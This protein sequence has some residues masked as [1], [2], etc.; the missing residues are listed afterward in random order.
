MAT[1]WIDGPKV[2]LIVRHSATTILKGISTVR[3][4]ASP[5]SLDAEFVVNQSN[6]S[7]TLKCIIDVNQ[8]NA[9]ATLKGITIIRHEVTKG[10][11]TKFEVTHSEELK[12]LFIVRHSASVTLKG[13]SVIRHPDNLALRAEFRITVEGWEMQ[14]LSAAVYRDLGVIS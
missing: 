11:F 10:L 14:G 8:S 4:T 3:H 2:I 9:S 12:G 5:L 7:A 1:A 13:I 6:A